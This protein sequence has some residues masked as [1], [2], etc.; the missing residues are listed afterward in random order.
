MLRSDQFH[1]KLQGWDIITG[2]NK[3]ILPLPSTMIL[4]W[5]YYLTNPLRLDLR[6]FAGYADSDLEEFEQRI[7]MLVI[8]A[9]TNRLEEMEETK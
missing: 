4:R 5:T 3:H 9:P 7:I 8:A 2:A 1:P 6:Y